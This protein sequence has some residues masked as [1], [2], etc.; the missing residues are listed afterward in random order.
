LQNV[1]IQAAAWE[2]FKSNFKAILAK[3]DVSFG[4]GLAGVAGDLCDGRLRDDSQEFFA[5]QNIPGSERI[6]QNTKN[7]VN[8]CI[9]VRSLQQANLSEFLKHSSATRAAIP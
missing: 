5:N 8:E 9:E 1:Y 7:W 2:L 6:L 3:A 4:A